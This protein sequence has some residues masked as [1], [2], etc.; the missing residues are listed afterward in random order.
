M[1]FEARDGRTNA[2]VFVDRT[3]I[4]CIL[5]NLVANSRDAVGESG[6]VE[7]EVDEVL[8][9]EG[10]P[11]VHVVLVVRDT[12]AGMDERTLATRSNC[13]SDEEGRPRNGLGLAIVR[14]IAGFAQGIIRVESAPGEGTLSA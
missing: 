10:A 7:I 13:S 6:T 9:A 8:Q 4:R 12:G 14:T 1:R 11:G 5:F 2:R 3:D